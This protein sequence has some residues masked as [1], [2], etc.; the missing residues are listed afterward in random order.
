M[1]DFIKPKA[2]KKKK[3]RFLSACASL[4]TSRVRSFFFRWSNYFR[5]ECIQPTYRWYGSHWWSRVLPEQRRA[6]WLV[7]TMLISVCVVTQWSHKRET[8]KKFGFVQC[9]AHH[10]LADMYS[11]VSKGVLSSGGNFEFGES[12]TA[13]FQVHF[14][15]QSVQGG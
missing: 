15:F 4:K 11:Y 6:A 14:Q 9:E 7:L 3:F 5:D 8:L 13:T 1:P 10:S 2:K 12:M